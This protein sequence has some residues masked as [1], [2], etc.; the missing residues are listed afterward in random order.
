MTTGVV[1]S[2]EAKIASYGYRV[3][4]KNS[5]TE[6]EE[7]LKLSLKRVKGWKTVGPIPREISRHYYIMKAEDGFVNGAVIS[8]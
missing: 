1:Y 5:W 8:T 6:M 4:K 7:R 3:H 2:F